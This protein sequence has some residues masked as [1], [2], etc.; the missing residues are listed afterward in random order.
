MLLLLM[1]VSWNL[2]EQMA[3]WGDMTIKYTEI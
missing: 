2:H 3:G 1:I